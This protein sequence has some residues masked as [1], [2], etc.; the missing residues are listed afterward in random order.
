MFFLLS[1]A[2]F[3][4]QFG[5]ATEVD[6]LSIYDQDSSHLLSD[7]SMQLFPEEECDNP[8]TFSVR[9]P[10]HTQKVEYFAEDYFLGESTNA[11]NLF[12]VTYDFFLFG[13]RN[14]KAIAFD[15]EDKIISSVENTVEIIEETYLS[16]L[17]DTTCE[18]PCTFTAEAS[19]DIAFVKYYVDGWFIGAT[20]N[21]SS[22]FSLT[23]DFQNT[24]IR[25]LSI[26]GFYADRTL[27]VERKVEINVEPNAHMAYVEVPYFYQ[28]ANSLYPS[29]SCQNTSIAMVLK[30]YGWNGVPDTITAEWG[31]NYAQDPSGLA[32][33][34]NTL[35]YE[36]GIS[37]RLTPVTNGT[38]AQL[39]AELDAGNPTIIHGYFTGYG[40]VM[41]VL[42]YDSNGYYVNDP[43]G[44]WSQTFKGGYPYGWNSNVGRA[45]YYN[46]TAFEK[47][48]A[49]WDGYTPAPLWFHKIR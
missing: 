40:H 30:K 20:E 2:C 9:A 6:S 15:E 37:K 8:C 26:Q 5:S 28:Y 24:G 27:A 46:K 25:E 43:A 10:T 42:G 33:I 4:N 39:R 49:T 35:A 12:S 32:D 44:E 21:A 17:S 47:A 1:L 23:Y 16:L 22:D 29:S 19:Q 38:L 3:Q 41:V 45:I 7:S 11:A 13:E 36:H 31:K 48:V 34:F 14:I 18:N